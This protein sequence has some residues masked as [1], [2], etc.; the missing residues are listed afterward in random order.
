MRI[1]WWQELLGVFGLAARP[2]RP[3][4]RNRLCLEV[5]E[6]RLTPSVTVTSN[7]GAITIV[8]SAV[9]TATLSLSGGAYRITDAAGINAASTGG[10]LSGGNTIFTA[11]DA[12][13]GQS[14]FTIGA[15][16]AGTVQLTA[17]NVIPT[18]TTVTINAGSLDLGGFADAIDALTGS[19]TVT[20]SGAA[21]TFT[22]GSSGGSGTFS[23]VIT[24][25]AN[26]LNLVKAGAGTETLSGSNAYG[27]TTSITA[28]TVADGIATA[29]MWRRSWIE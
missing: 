12:A 15:G 26:A 8:F 24:N 21:V 22:I 2:Q 5:L 23:G 19:G 14:P 27:G 7:P 9:E 29:E 1:L 20:N 10:V 17:A 4:A 11:N 6:D 28:G 3:H 13:A 16:S 18:T 25:G